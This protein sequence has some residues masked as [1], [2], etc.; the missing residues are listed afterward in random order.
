MLQTVLSNPLF[1]PIVVTL[2]II[3][4]FPLVAGYIVLV[5]RKV[6]A[7]FQVRLGPMRVGPHGL[8]Q[9]LADALKL[10]I[11]EDIIPA[12]SDKAIFWF[13]PCLST[14]T[15]LTA[16]SVLPFART[17]FVADV[18]VGLLVVSAVSSVGILGII[19]GGW[20][21]NSH[22]SLLGAL[23]SAAQLV[24]Y[25]VAL[26]F[27]LISGV[28]AAGTLSMQGIIQAQATRG[29]WFVF[30]NY[31][32]MI[33][34]FA[35]YLIAATAE[36][37]RA[38]FDLPEAESELVGGFHT[39]YSGFRW[40][41]YFLAEYANVFVVASVAV[42]LFWG[43][44]LRPF[45][46]VKWLDIPLNMGFP[47]VLFVGSGLMSLTLVKKLKDAMQQK[48]LVGASLLLVLVAGVFVIP[49]IN[50]PVS[51]MFWFL[52]KVSTIIYTLIWFRGTFPRFRYDQLMN[53]GW[54]IAIPVG[55]AAVVINA[56]LGMTRPVVGS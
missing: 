1:T 37:N 4:L 41:L 40:C 49:A 19:L 56:V 13:A 33:V 7:D 27:A 26:A 16:F 38:P 22:F 36:T 50:A 51:G 20:S 28:M 23:R 25:E 21:S 8:L 3:A 42:T 48:V 14:I 32:F 9:P 11:K 45:P 47:F 5:E 43:G 29:I 12:E 6:L 17:I 46:S 34:P 2:A 18:N 30:D 55:M 39:E 52:F 53:I 24:S 15:A 35:V 44:W 54:K 31:G 10:L